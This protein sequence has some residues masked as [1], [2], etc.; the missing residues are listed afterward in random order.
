LRL[1]LV[2]LVDLT[3]L[4]SSA[5]APSRG[6]GQRV[7]GTRELPAG[8][9]VGLLDM[10]VAGAPRDAVTEPLVPKVRTHYEDQE[11]TYEG[12]TYVYTLW[13]REV[14]TD[15]A[16]APVMVPRGDQV[17]HPPVAA[18][19]DQW[20]R[21]WLGY[22][23]A[24]ENPPDPDVA[25]LG[26]WLRVRTDWACDF[27]PAVDEFASEVRAILKRLR[28]A[29]STA[30][31]VIRLPEP[32]PSCDLKVLTRVSGTDQVRCGNPDCRRVWHV[33]RAVAVLASRPN[34]AA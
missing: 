19:L 34:S 27:H 8:A 2:E 5:L 13:W 28:T 1:D 23:T 31:H 32:C 11:I 17:G 26:N 24:G 25:S 33:D 6:H 4:I 15:E 30:R 16:G 22:R 20:V 7:S 12:Q 10:I 3:A 29:L 14:V 21:D 9:R 18:V